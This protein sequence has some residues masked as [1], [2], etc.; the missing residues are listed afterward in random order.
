MSTETD[1]Q[2]AAVPRRRR[3]NLERRALR[4]EIL[5][6]CENSSAR[7]ALE[8]AG[9]AKGDRCTQG[10]LTDVNR[11]PDRPRDP[12]PEEL[13]AQEPVAMFALD[14]QSKCLPEASDIA[15]RRC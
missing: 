3:H 14:E 7:Q 13:T 11:G 4:A 12:L 8:L 9:K 1:D 10:L 5:I 6:L 15:T 2:K